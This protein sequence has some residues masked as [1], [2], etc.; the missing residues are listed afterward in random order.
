[1]KASLEFWLDRFR[2][3]RHH[4]PKLVLAVFVLLLLLALDSTVGVI[5]SIIAVALLVLYGLWRPWPPE[6]THRADD[7]SFNA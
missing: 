5:A 6:I 3:Q 7:R 4:A 2:S 1:M